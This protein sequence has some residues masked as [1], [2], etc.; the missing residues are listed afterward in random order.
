M[1]SSNHINYFQEFDK[2]YIR[3]NFIYVQRGGEARSSRRAHNPQF[4][5]SNLLP[6]TYFPYT[7]NHE[8]DLSNFDDLLI[9][10]IR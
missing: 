4:S 8:R 5:S 2:A 6:A 10:P 1:S 3:L 7:Q 9:I